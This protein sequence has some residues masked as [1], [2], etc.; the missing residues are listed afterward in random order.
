MNIRRS[1]AFTIVELLIVIVVIAILAAISIVAYNGIQDRAR[2]SAASTA[3]SQAARK[4]A[5]YQVDNGSYPAT[6]SLASAGV[7]NSN[8]TYYQYTGSG[9]TYCLTASVSGTSYNVSNTHQAPQAGA[10]SGQVD[11]GV[12]TNLAMNPR[13]QTNAVS[14]S[15]TASGGSW[16]ANRVTLVSGLES[17]GINTAHRINMTADAPTWW[18][19]QLGPIPVSPNTTYSLSAYIRPNI[20]TSTGVIIIWRNSSGS[21]I[22]ESGGGFAGQSPMTWAKKTVTATAPSTAASVLIHAGGTN[23]GTSGSY[24]DTTGVIFTEGSTQYNFA[25][26]NTTDW[27]WNGTPN[28]STSTGPPV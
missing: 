2:A 20:T 7:S 8:S 6:G 23:N 12:V 13:A 15:G 26:G 9:S 14:W 5:L 27:V 25:D 19:N 1:R 18:R 10:C 3:A 28:N 21:Y 17:L 22:S 11:G 16:S 24:I 4:L